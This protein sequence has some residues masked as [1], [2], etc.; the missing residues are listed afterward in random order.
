MNGDFRKDLEP[1]VKRVEA[2]ILALVRELVPS[3]SLD[4]IGPI[5]FGGVASWSCWI[6]TPTD[7]EREGVTKDATLMNNLYATAT[8][9]GFAPDSITVQSQ[10]T[11]DR[12][13]E[14]SWFY[15]MR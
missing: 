3:G 6:V 7:W 15:A 4:R 13:Y 1:A 2:A 9:A 8:G 10:E 5:E 11:V 14:G 12:D